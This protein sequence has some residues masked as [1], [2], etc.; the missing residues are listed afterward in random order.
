MN[1]RKPKKPKNPRK[2]SLLN[3]FAITNPDYL[4]Y[5]KLALFISIKHELSF[6]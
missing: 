3:S 1:P 4:I 2:P 6:L 5:I